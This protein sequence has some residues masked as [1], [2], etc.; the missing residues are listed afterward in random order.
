[1]SNIHPSAIISPGAELAGD[2]RVG[3]YAIIGEHVTIGAGSV[4]GAHA[5]VDGHTDLGT[6]NVIHAHASIGCAPQDK[7]YRNE[8][9][10]LVI[11][12]NNT[13]FQSV[14]IAVGTVQDEGIT[15]L[16]DDNWLMAYAHIGHDCRIGNSTIFANSA[17]LGGHVVVQDHAILGGLSAVHQFCVIGAHAMAGGGSIIVQ[18]LPP[19]TICEGNRAVARGINSEGLKRRGFTAEQILAVKRAYKLLYR[20]GSSYEVAVAQIRESAAEE[21]ALQA[22]VEFFDRS[23]RGI[24]R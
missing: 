24:L 5:I 13:I 18:D 19:F 12:N 7:K 11:G 2:V 4:I 22:F 6:G 9:T 21:P 15:S 23:R 14:T 17:T 20:S 16:G 8:P 3:P 1:M 10:R